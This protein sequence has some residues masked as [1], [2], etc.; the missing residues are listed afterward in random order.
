MKMVSSARVS[1]RLAGHII[2]WHLLSPFHKPS[3][4]LLLGSCLCQFRVPHRD[5]PLWDSSC[6]RL[7]SHLARAEGFG[8]WFPN[9]YMEKPFLLRC[10]WLSTS[11]FGTNEEQKPRQI[12]E[13][14]WCPTDDLFGHRGLSLQASEEQ[15]LYF[16]VFSAVLH[17]QFLTLC[18]FKQKEYGK[19][20]CLVICHSILSP[21]FY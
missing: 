19:E 12:T 5:L 11:H 3:R 16:S 13:S 18:N 14:F 21:I 8:W 1:G 2:S 6:K 17:T 7:L 9:S 15:A 20:K 4:I 10:Q